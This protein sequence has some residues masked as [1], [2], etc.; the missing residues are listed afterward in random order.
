M[1]KVDRLR[2]RRADGTV[3][4]ISLDQA[5]FFLPERALPFRRP[6]SYRKQKNLPGLY[7]FETTGRHVIYE[8]LLEMSVLQ[9]LD[10]DPDVVA[11]TAQP[12][13]MLLPLGPKPKR[14]VPDYFVRLLSGHGRVVEVK[15]SK[16]A[17]TSKL[18]RVLSA[19]RKVCAEVGWDYEVATE[20][21]AVTIANVGWLAGYRRKPL[22]LEDFADPLIEAAKSGVALD[23]LLKV[24]D[25]EALVRPILFHLLWKHV[26]KAD[27]T[28]PLSGSTIVTATERGWYVGS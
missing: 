25:H 26:L 15:P 24:F 23:N 27:L 1:K 17:E 9:M 22:M 21:E 11:V 5:S 19:A 2:Y 10:F 7:W 20:F 13:Q 28:V 12:F 16:F 18:R 4:G 3:V 6:P 8:S 14:Y